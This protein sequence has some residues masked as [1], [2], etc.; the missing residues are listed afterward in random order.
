MHKHW[1]LSTFSTHFLYWEKI[2]GNDGHIEKV[3]LSIFSCSEVF[4]RIVQTT[5][6]TIFHFF[7]EYF[8]DVMD[9]H[10]SPYGRLFEKLLFQT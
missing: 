3:N 6:L 5:D 1:V 4:R 9:V 7:L 2:S 8:V 10:I